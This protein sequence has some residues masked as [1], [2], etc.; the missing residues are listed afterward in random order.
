MTKLTSLFNRDY[1]IRGLEQILKDA[2]SRCL[3][4][5]VTDPI[6]S[7]C[8]K[9]KREWETASGRIGNWTSLRSNQV[10]VDTDIC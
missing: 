8:A 1:C 10:H 2:V 3:D 7:S 4:S 5:W 9:G 6:G